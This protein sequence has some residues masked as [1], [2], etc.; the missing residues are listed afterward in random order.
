[1]FQSN[2]NRS[3]NILSNEVKMNDDIGNAHIQKP[4]T[5]PLQLD[6]QIPDK[7]TNFKKK[8]NSNINDSTDTDEEGDD[9]I[10]STPTNPQL[11]EATTSATE[12]LGITT[13][14]EECSY[15]SEYDHSDSQVD[16]SENGGE[17]DFAPAYILNPGGAGDR[18]KLT[19]NNIL[20]SVHNLMRHSFCS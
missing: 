9:D 6:I 18:S 13:N 1:M 17:Y 8:L 12:W 4:K 16:Q 19:F 15:S 14:S 20:R 3:P 5:K 2:Q 11:T 7:F 10:L